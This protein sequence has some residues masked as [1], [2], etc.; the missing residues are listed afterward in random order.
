MNERINADRKVNTDKYHAPLEKSLVRILTPFEA[1]IRR[2]T[3]SGLQ[4]MV[5][6][7]IFTA[8]LLVGVAGFV[9]SAG[10]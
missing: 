2:Q 6:T 3:T 4:L 8:S 7:G 10:R 9:W 5:G 1:F